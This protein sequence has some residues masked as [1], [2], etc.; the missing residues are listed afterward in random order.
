M[1]GAGGLL[2]LFHARRL[3]NQVKDQ[4]HILDGRSGWPWCRCL[5]ILWGCSASCMLELALLMHL[6]QML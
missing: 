6:C 1:E 3:L 5:L 4:R 2:T